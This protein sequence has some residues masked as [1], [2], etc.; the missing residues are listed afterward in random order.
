MLSRWITT[1]KLQ[2]CQWATVLQLE[3]AEYSISELNVQ[4]KGWNTRIER[5]PVSGTPIRWRLTFTAVPWL[6]ITGKFLF[7][8]HLSVNSLKAQNQ[9]IILDRKHHR[10][11]SLWKFPEISIGDR[12]GGAKARLTAKK[13]IHCNRWPWP[14]KRRGI[15][16]AFKLYTFRESRDIG[17]GN[18]LNSPWKR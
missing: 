14:W 8:R 17:F 16:T 4:D 2:K 5:N 15:I 10:T 13:Y 7:S 18:I 9:S 11:G 1:W 6:L 3:S 12:R